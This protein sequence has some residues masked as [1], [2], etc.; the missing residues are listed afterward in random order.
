MYDVLYQPHRRWFGDC[1]PVHHD[2]TFYLFHQRDTRRLGP[3][4]EPFGWSLVTT[5]DFVSYADHGD[6]IPRGGDDEQDRFIY[7]GSVFRADE[8]FYAY[9]TGHNS[10]YA[11]RGLP[12][13]V[14]MTATSP[15]LVTWTK[16]GE[17]LAPPEPGY[18]PDDWRDP[19]VLRDPASGEY[20]MILGARHRAES[21][22]LTGATVYFTSPDLQA[23]TFRG[24]LWGPGLYTMHQMPDLFAIGDTWYLLAHEYSDRIRTIYRIGDSPTGPWRTPADDC[25]DGRAYYAA[26]TA[27]DGERRYLF[28]W[29]PTREGD[30]DVGNW[31]WGGTLLVHEVVQRADGSLGTALPDTIRRAY[32]M[33][34]EYLPGPI[35]LRS[36]GDLVERQLGTAPSESFVL[37]AT[38]TI[39]DPTLQIGIRVGEDDAG[40][41]YEFRLSPVEGRLGFGRR[42]N[43]RWQ[44]FTGTGLDRP[45]RLT[46]GREY[47]LE[48][49]VDHDIAAIYI[50]A[51]A[52]STR[53]CAP[54]GRRVSIHVVDGA[55]LLHQARIARRAS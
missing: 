15:D 13:E 26:R 37:T 38:I 10:S 7:A 5:S 21:R 16:T 43:P 39:T 29:V 24:D 18:D 1:M 9:Y 6:V 27:S 35:V 11:S 17:R 12:T 42:P 34:T 14:L 44:E 33:V 49:I 50:D 52:L 32:G 53:M 4:G 51:V 28:G 46:T 36:T 31:Q 48:V 54:P 47:T 45:L 40:G 30:S 23:W 19:F 2:G 25:F 22:Q 20:M 8:T 55:V 41:G 3:L